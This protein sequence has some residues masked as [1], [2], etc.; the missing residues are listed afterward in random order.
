MTMVALSQVKLG[1]KIGE[2]V[3]TPL[4]GVLLNKGKIIT[5]REIEIMQ[6]FLVSTVVT[7]SGTVFSAKSKEEERVEQKQSE[8]QPLVQ[9]PLNDEYDQM[10]ALLKKVYNDFASGQGMPVMDI[11][12]QL[13]KLLKHIKSY[14]VLTFAPRNFQERDYLIH[15]SVSCALTSYLIA[16]W[17]GLPQKDWMQVALAG[18]LHDVGNTRLNRSILTKPSALTAEELEEMKR[19]PSLGYQLLKNVAALNEGVKLAAL[20]HHEREDGSGYPVGSDGSK[21]H[22]YAKIV[23]IAD[24]FH[25]M[26][27]DKSYRKAASPYLV[28]EQIQSD[29]FGKLEP[30]YVRTF[31]E[32]VTQF[33]NGTIV[34]LNNE[35]VGEI[36]FTDHN[37]PTRPWV[38]VEGAIINLT[39]ERNLYIVEVIR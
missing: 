12:V 23:A 37:H 2:D 24:I 22:P 36:V 27:M 17:V 19:H 14:S 33:H 8:Q 30:S 34:K 15:N 35:R 32:K 7:D 29:A 18:L 1:D 11:R 21:I 4:G 3:L 5:Q 20:Q 38:N 10:I 28:L 9:S 13:E 16:Q 31:V 25:A 26:T 6:A 39:V